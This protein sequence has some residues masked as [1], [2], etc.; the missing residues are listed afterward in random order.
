M[1]TL[2]ED[3][4]ER[5]RLRN[6]SIVRHA[7]VVGLVVVVLVV[8]WPLRET[9]N[10]E[11]DA[12]VALTGEFD[13][14]FEQVR[15]GELT[16]PDEPAEIVPGIHGAQLFAGGRQI[17]ALVGRAESRC[18]G[19]WWDEQLVRRGRVLAGDLPCEPVREIVSLSPRDFERIAAAEL[20]P[21]AEFD[22]GRV[23]PDEMRWRY[24]TLPLLIVGFWIGLS[25][26]VR[27]SIMLITQQPLRPPR[28]RWWSRRG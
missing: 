25:A 15:D 22:W 7:V 3:R 2:P 5:L 26:L 18:Y 27:I 21:S 19:M 28:G 4:E 9:R 23:L 16:L 11:H 12:A 10:E 13:A 20:D 14:L 1:P 8:V 17:G 6:R 24:W